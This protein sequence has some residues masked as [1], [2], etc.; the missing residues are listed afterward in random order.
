MKNTNY[1]A[2]HYVIVAGYHTAAER[3]QSNCTQWLVT[4]S[5][6]VVFRALVRTWNVY[7]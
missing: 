6:I 2:P 4:L 3:W 7:E 5:E 1:D